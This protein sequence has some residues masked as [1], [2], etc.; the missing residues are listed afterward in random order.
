MVLPEGLGQLN[1]P[2]TQ[3][4]IEP[5]FSAVPQPTV[6]PRAPFQTVMLFCKSA[7]ALDRK[8]CICTYWK[9]FLHGRW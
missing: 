2:M 1:I 8:V 5:A 3:S 7:R 6:P 4:G 9:Q